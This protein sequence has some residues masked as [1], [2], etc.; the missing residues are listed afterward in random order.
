MRSICLAANNATRNIH[1]L[2]VNRWMYDNDLKY[3]HIR[4]VNA[5][6]P[7]EVNKLK[8]PFQYNRNRKRISVNSQ[9]VPQVGCFIWLTKLCSEHFI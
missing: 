1:Q 9:G 2:G 7:E 3:L 5:I 4:S 6:K 8:V